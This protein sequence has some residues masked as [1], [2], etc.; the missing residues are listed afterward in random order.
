MAALAFATAL[1]GPAAA[2][3]AVPTLNFTLGQNGQPV[4]SPAPFEP[5]GAIYTETLQYQGQSIG[6]L[7]QPEDV[8]ID[9]IWHDLWVVDTNNNRIIELAQDR[10][11]HNVP[12]FDQVKLIIGGPNAQGDA[13][14]NQP[15]GVAVG[16][17]GVIYVADTGNGRI[18]TFA[19]NGTF[20]KSLDTGTSL[21]LQTQHVKFVPDKVA[22]D[23]RGSIYVSI[24][25]QAYG[26]AQFNS[27]GQFM[28]FFAP[29]ALGFSANLR[30]RLGRL[31]ETQQQKAQQETVLP[32]EVNNV[33]VGPDGYIYTT[34]ISVNSKQLRRL[35]VVGADTLNRPGTSIQYGLPID[36]LPNYVFEAIM[37]NRQAQMAAG[38]NSG[39]ISLQ[40]LFASIGADNS[41]VITALDQLS[42]FVFQYG[43]EGQ[44]LYTFGGLDNGNGVLG[45]FEE[46]TAV[47]VTPDGY[48]VVSDGLEEN[49]QVFQPTNFALLAQ[50][51]VELYN[52]GK[53]TDAEAPWQQILAMDTNYDLAHAQLGQGYLAEGQ[54][55]GA[56]PSVLPAEL[57]TFSKAIHQFYVGDDKKDFGV[58]FGWY[59]HIWMRINFTWVFLSFLGL[60][61]LV[62]LGFRI[63]GR[64][65]RENPIAFH[66]A[67]ARNQ[68]VRIVPMAWRVIKH[69][70][71]AFFQLKYEEQGTFWQGIVL[72]VLAFLVHLGNLVWTNFDFS[73]IE[74]GQTSL[75][76]TSSQF[77]LP[78]ATWIVANYLVGDLYEGEANLGE[79]LTGSAY[80]LL[81]FIVLQLPYALFTH[82]LVPTDGVFRDLFLIQKLWLVYLFFTQVRV[83][84][85]LEWGQA[86]KAT[87]MTLVGIGVI[88]TM[89]LIVT[90]LGQQ[91]YSFVREIIREALLLRS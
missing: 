10:D 13:A 58:A 50:K 5:V 24:A 31:L 37:Q 82:A 63:L 66:G 57:A 32:P 42:G 26:L 3:A 75:L 33:Y 68:F 8:Y 30:Y 59:R 12:R 84:H 91:A 80:A 78:L 4:P 77:L 56:D 34:S 38:Q 17:D 36:A 9:N 90:G 19:P 40:P 85:N 74:R 88:W 54:L 87:L 45:L 60:W 28:G 35:N 29:N 27:N 79:V 7:N 16:P 43:S 65:L 61:L 15:K 64:R 81:P 70:A 62:Y 18:A 55:M 52:V 44:L 6:Q 76:F 20:L 11:S 21:T 86:I 46:P 22:V 89:F 67:W 69:P 53:Y 71:E 51:G 47:A 39:P 83:L 25:G 23:D 1:V 72:I 14:L 2:L 48:V 49:L 41:G 73:A